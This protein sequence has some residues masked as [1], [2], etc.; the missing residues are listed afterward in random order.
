MDAQGRDIRPNREP[1]PPRFVVPLRKVTGGLVSIEHERVTRLDG[2]EAGRAQLGRGELDSSD[3][4]K[5]AEARAPVVH[6]DLRRR[7]QIE[8]ENT[9][10]EGPIN[11]KRQGGTRIGDWRRG[12]EPRGPSDDIQRWR[13]QRDQNAPL[14]RTEGAGR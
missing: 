7:R 3:H 10:A 12:P 11:S 5:I 2:D 4:W 6:R 1:A 13:E 14:G 9:G 8:P